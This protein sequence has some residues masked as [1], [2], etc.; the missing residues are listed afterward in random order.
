MNQ[1]FGCWKPQKAS[2]GRAIGLEPSLPGLRRVRQHGAA[3]HAL[4][5]PKTAQCRIRQSR[6]VLY[7]NTPS[8]MPHEGVIWLL[9]AIVWYS[10]GLYGGWPH[11]YKL[12]R[13]NRGL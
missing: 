2:R 1:W 11:N 8:R 6:N 13:N 5:D 4:R 9:A 7:R 3:E 12:C 10:A